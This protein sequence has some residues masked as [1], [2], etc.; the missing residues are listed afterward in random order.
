MAALPITS[1]LGDVVC[2]PA[3]PAGRAAPN[4]A[5]TRGELEWLRGAA[6][7]SDP[8]IVEQI[9]FWDSGPPSYRWMDLIVKRQ[10]AGQALSEA[11]GKLEQMEKRN[12]GG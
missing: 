4:A 6:A 10:N 1:A 9:R 3:Q 5:A 2:P 8:R 7:E 12:S 11:R